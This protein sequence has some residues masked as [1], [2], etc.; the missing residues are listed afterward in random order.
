MLQPLDV[1]EVTFPL[2]G[3]LADLQAA[4]LVI[5][6]SLAQQGVTTGVGRLQSAFTGGTELQPKSFTVSGGKPPKN[7]VL[8]AAYSAQ[9]GTPIIDVVRIKRQTITDVNGRD[10][11][12][13]LF[14]IEDAL[15]SVEL[16][17]NLVR[18]LPVRGQKTVKQWTATGDY[19]I[20]ISFTI[21]GDGDIPVDLLN[22]VTLISKCNATLEVEC[23]F[24]Q[25]QN[26]H[27]ICIDR[28][29]IKQTESSPFHMQCSWQCYSDDGVDVLGVFGVSI[30]QNTD[31]LVSA[32]IANNTA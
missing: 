28:P 2:Q 18:T 26:I 10:V 4:P 1:K 17:K 11:I 6:Q 22:A 32:D 5:Q 15:I 14:T 19:A 13:P 27:T 8:P 9:L 20:D 29:T 12:I 31:G 23:R 21:T 30:G 7:T 3:A 24:L 25:T 16:E